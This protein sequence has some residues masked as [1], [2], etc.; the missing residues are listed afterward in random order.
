M[1][2]SFSR[3]GY[4]REHISR[5]RY[6]SRRGGSRCAP[7]KSIPSENYVPFI[8]KLSL[9]F[10]WI[11]GNKENGLDNENAAAPTV[12]LFQQHVKAAAPPIARCAEGS[13]RSPLLSLS[14][15]GCGGMR[16]C[17][18]VGRTGGLVVRRECRRGSWHEELALSA[19]QKGHVVE[20]AESSSSIVSPEDRAECSALDGPVE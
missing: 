4:L 12:V 9:V 16:A 2:C 19:A 13:D 3:G 7:F 5:R 14:I 18:Q 15:D 6:N 8:S 20:H 11:D 17:G 10:Y 1:C